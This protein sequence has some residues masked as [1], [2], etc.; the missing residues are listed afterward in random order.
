MTDRI[1]QQLRG[2]VGV[3]GVMIYDRTTGEISKLLPSKF[4]SELSEQLEARLRKMAN[5]IPGGTILRMR[6]ESGWLVLRGYDDYTI[7]L[8]AKSDL[9][10]D[11]LKIVLSAAQTAMRHTA[12]VHPQADAPPK[13]LDMESALVLA[14]TVG[15]VSEHFSLA[16]GAGPAS[17]ANLLRKTKAELQQDFPVLKHF[18][19]DN[20]GRIGIIKGS[21]QRLDRSAAEGA[22]WWCALLR[23]AA[24]A[25]TPVFGFDVRQI[26][27]AHEK[28]LTSLGF[29][30]TFQRISSKSGRRISS[31][32]PR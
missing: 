21:E 20:N 14:D 6:F 12:P 2:V 30:S 15:R 10:F 7:L 28:R 17:A 11:T 23:D 18:S 27:V 8:I 19:V 1:L 5:S 32:Q 4:D 26:T 25:K 24:E 13:E 22:A 9:N 31:P 3:S 16:L 29:Y